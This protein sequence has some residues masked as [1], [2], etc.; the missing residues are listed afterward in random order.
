MTVYRQPSENTASSYENNERT[1]KKG[2][3]VYLYKLD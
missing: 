1:K 3:E 2:V